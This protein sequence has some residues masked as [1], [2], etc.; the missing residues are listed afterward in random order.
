MADMAAAR[1]KTI[2]DLIGPGLAIV[3]CGINPGLCSAAAGH[4]PAARVLFQ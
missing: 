2:P 1:G 3:F 4:R